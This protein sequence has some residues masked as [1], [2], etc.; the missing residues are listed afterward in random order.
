MR[1]DYQL[2]TI[3]QI[4]RLLFC[5]SSSQSGIFIQMR[6]QELQKICSQKLRISA[7]E[8]LEIA[9][10][11]YQKGFVTANITHRLC[12]TIKGD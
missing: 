5:I 2:S 1:S 6:L 4:T 9:E 7:S 12:F 3:T 8:T 11:L 10:S